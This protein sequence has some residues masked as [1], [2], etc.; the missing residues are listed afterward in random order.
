MGTL[1]AIG[2]GLIGAIIS[3]IAEY[4]DDEANKKFRKDA[5]NIMLQQAKS[6]TDLLRENNEL[7]KLAKIKQS[8]EEA[9]AR[10]DTLEE[11]NR[12]VKKAEKAVNEL[13]ELM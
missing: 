1:V 2:I 8:V 7:R 10:D 12:L 6:N 5:C 4:S 11:C 9:K 13:N 3:G